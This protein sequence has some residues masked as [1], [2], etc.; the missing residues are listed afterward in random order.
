MISK[1]TKPL[2]DK[3][4]EEA[5]VSITKKV[6]CFRLTHY[7][8]SSRTKRSARYLKARRGRMVLLDVWPFHEKIFDKSPPGA[9]WPHE[10]GKPFGPMLAYFLWE[11]QKDDEFW[12][13]KLKGTLNRIHVTALSL[14]LTTNKPAYYN[15]LS[16]ES[17]PARKIYRENM[18]WLS[19]VKKE[20]DPRDV[21]GR[22]GGHKIPVAK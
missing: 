20:Y 7:Y 4:A 19:E 22:C 11:D 10:P 12:L 3:M 13:R 8:S 6:I 15:N 9:A 21:M 17:V 16:L 18:D 1:Y 5:E 14:G 2:L